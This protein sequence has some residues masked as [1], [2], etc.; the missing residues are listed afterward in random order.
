MASD[1]FLFR[2]VLGSQNSTLKCFDFTPLLPDKAMKSSRDFS[3]PFVFRE[4]SPGLTLGMQSVPLEK[5]L[6]VS[7]RGSSWTMWNT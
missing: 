3:V 1:G 6:V 4:T 2:R 5:S 7:K